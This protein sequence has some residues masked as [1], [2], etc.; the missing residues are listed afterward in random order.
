MNRLALRPLIFLLA[1]TALGTV[2]AGAAAGQSASNSV[3]NPAGE[4]AECCS[5][6]PGEEVEC[7]FTALLEG[8]RE[9]TIRSRFSEGVEFGALDSI[10]CGGEALNSAFYTLLTGDGTCEVHLASRFSPAEPTELEICY[11]VRLNAQAVSLPDRND[12]ALEADGCS[13]GESARI[14][15]CAVKLFR[16]VSL[17]EAGR[18]SNP[19]P[20]VCFS[21]Y[22]D[23]QLHVRVAFEDRGD[24][25]YEACS[26][27]GCGHTRHVFLLRS[28]ENGIIRLDGLRAGKYYLQEERT[29]QGYRP[30]ASG[31][32]IVL[33]S[34][35]EI[36]AGG[37]PA[38]EGVVVLAE[39]SPAS[40]LPEKK[41]DPLSFYVKGC[42]FL[43]AALAVMLLERK[44]LFR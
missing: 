36:T 1:L 19:L 38:P 6:M 35:G 41:D 37:V 40:P 13:S 34:S 10:R 20:G 26:G 2:R 14:E 25:T 16:A 4:W 22:R 30:M 11:T 42:R 24:S 7:R 27:L 3:R 12:C 29:P 8:G 18:Q 28:P 21:L 9:H 32:E 15:T 31:L 33:S 43:A 17:P 5:A 39:P 44:R 23:A